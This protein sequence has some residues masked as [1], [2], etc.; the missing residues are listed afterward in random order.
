[1]EIFRRIYNGLKNYCGQRWPKAFGFVTRYRMFIK[2]VISGGSAALTDI[3]L[4]YFFT[5]IVDIW[6]L[7]S[8]VLAF[9]AALVVSF[10]LQKFWTF[11]D[12]SL[13]KVHSQFVLTTIVALANLGLNTLFMYILVDRVGLWY[14]L[15]QLITGAT[16]ALGSFT[17]YRKI[18]FKNTPMF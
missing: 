5:E 7:A 1:M 2:Y 16:L 17:A 9:I 15:A 14:I 13:D 6:Y 11:R 12:A 18:I 4:L 3:I 10:M 8:S